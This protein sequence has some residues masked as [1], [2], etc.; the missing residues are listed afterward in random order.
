[1]EKTNTKNLLDYRKVALMEYKDIK[2]L[3][4]EKLE[5][6]PFRSY[7]NRILNRYEDKNICYVDIPELECLEVDNTSDDN[8]EPIG[9]IYAGQLQSFNS[10]IG[11]RIEDSII[12][13][14]VNNI[15]DN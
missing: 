10:A 8:I 14:Q 4:E 7:G 3:L 15:Y 12:D 11:K 9:I 5:I 13:L 6:Y 2:K 1:M